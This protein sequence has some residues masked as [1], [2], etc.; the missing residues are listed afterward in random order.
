MYDVV[1]L[2]ETMVAFAPS[3]PGPLAAVPSF[4]P[5]IGGAESNVACALAAAGHAVAWVSRL[6]ADGFGDLVLRSVASYGVDVSAVERD[7]TRPTGVYFRTAAERSTTARDP[8]VAYY[9]AGSAASALAPGTAVPDTRILHLTGITPALSPGCGD[10]VRG[11]TA[12]RPGRPRVSF[13]VNYRPGLWR[14]AADAGLIFADLARGADVVFV[15]ADEAEALWGAADPQAVRALLPEP[16]VLVVKQGAA[17][18]T[19]LTGAGTVHV[20]ARRVEVVAAVGAGDAFAAGFLSATL[21][22]LPVRDALGR[23]HDFAARALSSHGDLAAP[24]QAARR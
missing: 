3:A 4:E 2:G 6:G 20:P 13:D 8:E 5:G 23:G 22:D 15:G 7:A 17:G 21:A 11:L 19:A 14:G 18:A 24:A 16:A 9:R 1:C 12:R 10:L